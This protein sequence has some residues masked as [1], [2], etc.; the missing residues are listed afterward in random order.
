MDNLH[1]ALFHARRAHA[2]TCYR[3]KSAQQDA[4]AFAASAMRLTDEATELATAIR[5]LEAM[6]DCQQHEEANGL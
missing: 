4:A 5:E 1:K 6:I 3:A 2:A